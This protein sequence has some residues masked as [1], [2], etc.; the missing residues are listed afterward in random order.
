MG[1]VSNL[2]PIDNDRFGH[3]EINPKPIPSLNIFPLSNQIEYTL[4]SLDDR[5]QVARLSLLGPEILMTLQTPELEYPDNHDT[6]WRPEYASYMI[7]GWSSCDIVR[8]GL[9]CGTSAGI[10]VIVRIVI[11]CPN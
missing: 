4:V 6:K 3:S 8:C 10:M 5:A 2:R 7:E 11:G 9:K 1:V